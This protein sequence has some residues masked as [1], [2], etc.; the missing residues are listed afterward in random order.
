MLDFSTVIDRLGTDSFKWDV[1]NRMLG[2]DDFI[3]M[4]CADM[5]FLTPP[6]IKQAMV[7]IAS[8]GLYG[9]TCKSDEFEQ[10]VASWMKERHGLKVSPATI[11]YAPRI[12]NITSLCVQAFSSP[13]DAVILNSPY[14]PPL[15]EITAANGRTVLKPHL[16]EREGRYVMDFEDLERQLEHHC[17]RMMI[18][19]SPH[20]PTGRI[21][22]REELEQ[23]ADFCVRHQIILFVDEIHSD[24]VAEGGKFTS[25]LALEGDITRYLIVTSAPSKTFNVMGCH[26][27]WIA[28]P[29]AQIRST[30]KNA[31]VRH[32]HTEPNIF[33]NTMMK[34][35]YQKCG[36]YVDE[37]NRVIDA[38]DAYLRKALPEV[39][40]GVI[41]KPREGT[42][43]L[44]V[45]FNPVFGS[46]KETMDF[47]HDRVRAHFHPG[48]HFGPG[49]DN[50]GRINIGCPMSVLEDFIER[51]RRARAQA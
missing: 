19:V 38:N 18:L 20:N 42:F 3:Q 46:E 44:W 6:E 50:F 49:F 51:I 24:F 47:F 37:V 15:N 33:G 35:A 12:V 22:T 45:D 21:W 43:L 16:V 7:S 30:V 9:Y 11:L 25:M 8:T 39:L 5:D 40:P 34:I 28:V 10:G 41:V 26:M 32:G 31:L 14:Y 13:G 1:P 17:V 27:S 29:D 2:G 23:V 48:S 4:G 36:Y